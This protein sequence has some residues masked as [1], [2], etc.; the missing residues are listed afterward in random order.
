M[1]NFNSVMLGTS[2]AKVMIEFYTKVFGPKM[3]MGEDGGDE[4][5]SW[6][7]G[8]GTISVGA[9]SE[10]MGNAKE[11]QRVMMNIETDQVQ[12]EFDRIKALGATV[13][14]EPYE[15]EGWEGMKIATLADPDGNYFQL[16]TPWEQS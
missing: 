2:Q 4:W 14:K 15:M 9:H 7:V 8:N 10:V 1:L 12:E 16:V 13:I 6:K 11:P 5:G 3:D